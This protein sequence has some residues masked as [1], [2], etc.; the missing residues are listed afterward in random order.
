MWRTITWSAYCAL[1]NDSRYMTPVILKPTGE[2]QWPRVWSCDPGGNQGQS[3]IT[4]R[5]RRG[6]MADGLR[7]TA[8]G[9]DK[10]EIRTVEASRRV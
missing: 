10:G 7:P 5:S 4:E 9:P 8:Y 3:P 6:V 2:E 1:W